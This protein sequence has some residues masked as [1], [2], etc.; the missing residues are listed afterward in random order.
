MKLLILCGALALIG[1]A[2]CASTPGQ[3]GVSDPFEPANRLVFAV[4]DQLD[5]AVVGPAARAYSGVTPEP[6][7]SSVRNVFRNLNRP[8]VLSNT[9]LQGRWSES[10]DVMASFVVDTVFG[11][12]G[13]IPIASSQGV[14]QHEEDFGQTLGAWGVPSGPFLMLPVVGPS[15]VRDGVGRLADRYP[16]PFNYDQDFSSQ[17]ATWAAR[18]LNGLQFR[19]DADTAFATLDRTA[20]DPYVQMR[21]A[22]RQARAAQIAN[23]DDAASVENLPDFD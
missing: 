22:Y 4:N 11:L 15:N 17:D 12:G 23:G 6:V 8:V 19:A 1:A 2:G 9:L 10:S 3:A 18:L 16:H 13:I 20:I 5:R 14:P 7:Q 21:S